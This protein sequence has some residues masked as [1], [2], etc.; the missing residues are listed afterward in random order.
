MAV[1]WLIIVFIFVFDPLAV[2]LL[3]AANYSFA[4]RHN[5]DNRQEEMFDGLFHKNEEK[6]LDNQEEISDNK[7]VNESDNEETHEVEDI[8]EEEEIQQELDA[9]KESD[10]I[11]KD[12]IEEEQEQQETVEETNQKSKNTE[13]QGVKLDPAEVDLEQVIEKADEKTLNKLKKDIDREINTKKERKSGWLD[14]LGSGFY[15]D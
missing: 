14:D 6:T 4:N 2:I 8:P 10:E 11:V 5:K 15:K 3:V 12:E 7:E 1:R 13:D 9:D